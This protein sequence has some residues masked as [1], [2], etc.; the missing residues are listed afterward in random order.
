M[1]THSHTTSRRTATL[2]AIKQPER[3]TSATTPARRGPSPVFVAN[4]DRE[5]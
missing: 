4:E 1:T 2:T 5:V 3:C